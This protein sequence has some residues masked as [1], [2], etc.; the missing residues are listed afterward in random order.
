MNPVLSGNTGDSDRNSTKSVIGQGSSKTPKK[1]MTFSA[2]VRLYCK[3][4]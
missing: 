1:A 4:K 2:L 3:G